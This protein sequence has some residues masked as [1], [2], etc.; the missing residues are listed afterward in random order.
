VTGS[1]RNAAPRY[2]QVVEKVVFSWADQKHPDAMRA[3][4]EE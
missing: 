4:Q 3:K 1:C 2:E